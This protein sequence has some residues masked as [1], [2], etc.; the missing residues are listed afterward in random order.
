MEENWDQHRIQS[1]IDN[2]V[3]ESLTLDYKIAASLSKQQNK[4]DEVTKDVSAMANSAGGLIIYGVAEYS[5]EDKKHLPEKIDPVDRT[6]FTKEWLEQVINNIRPRINTVV[7][8]PISIDTAPNHVVYV[9]EIPQSTT[10]HQANDKRYYKRFNFLS[11]AME[12]YEIRDVLNRAQY[13]Q[14][15]LEFYFTNKKAYP[16]I[17]IV[18]T[19]VGSIL[20][21]YLNI[22]IE[23]PLAILPPDRQ[24]YT[25]TDRYMSSFT[26]TTRDLVDSVPSFGSSKHIYGPS[27]YVPLLPKLKRQ[28]TYFLNSAF[29]PSKY[30]DQYLSWSIHTDNAPIIEGQ[31]AIGD[32]AMKASRIMSDKFADYD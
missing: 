23:F 26:N 24:Q 11:I 1:Y 21:Q 25:Q 18:A 7:I 8:H 4:K 9:V 3:E 28:W 14:I 22:F 15:E 16:E 17:H 27:R 5:A 13:P 20:A 19:N 31:I 12:D 32:I 10:A 29:D 6:E 2:E 30:A